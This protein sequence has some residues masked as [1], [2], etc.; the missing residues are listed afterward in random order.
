MNQHWDLRCLGPTPRSLVFCQGMQK[1]LLR[2][3]ILSLFGGKK[4][5]GTVRGERRARMD[6]V[7]L[8]YKHIQKFLS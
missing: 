8:N 1:L 3:E 6:M 5:R 7:K 4:K 2:K